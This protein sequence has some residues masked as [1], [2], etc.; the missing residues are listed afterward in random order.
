MSQDEPIGLVEKQKIIY[1]KL[2]KIDELINFTLEVEICQGATLKV[3]THE[4][5]AGGCAADSLFSFIWPVDVQCT[6]RR[7]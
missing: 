5:D 1:W 3:A 6:F 4:W 2:T 7:I